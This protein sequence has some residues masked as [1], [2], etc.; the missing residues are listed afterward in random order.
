MLATLMLRIRV[1]KCTGVVCWSFATANEV[2]PPNIFSQA[3]A[4]GSPLGR[5]LG[6]AGVVVFSTAAVLKV[7]SGPWL[8]LSGGQPGLM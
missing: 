2:K 6:Q 4:D 3:M 7:L 5:R 1:M 8:C